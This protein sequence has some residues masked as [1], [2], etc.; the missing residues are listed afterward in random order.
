VNS[1]GK[2]NSII[3]KTL[4]PVLCFSHDGVPLKFKKKTCGLNSTVWIV[5][6]WFQTLLNLAGHT[7]NSAIMFG[8]LLSPNFTNS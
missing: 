5:S 2:F 8:F 7:F 6:A 3:V 1:T 4:K